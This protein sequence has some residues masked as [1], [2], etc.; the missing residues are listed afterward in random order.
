MSPKLRLAIPLAA[1]GIVAVPATA[2]AAALTLPP[3]VRY[4]PGAQTVPIQGT[5]FTPGA[6]V[7]INADGQPIDS[8][9]AD[10]AGNFSGMFFAPSLSSPT[11]N[12][13]T[14]QITAADSAGQTSPPVAVPVTRVTVKLPSRARPR[15]RVRYRVFGFGSGQRV[16]LHVRRGGR[17]RGS[18]RIGT[19]RGACGN[20]TARQ[21]F[22]PLRRF[23]TGTYEYHFQHARRF[24]PDATV[25]RLQVI[26]TRTFGD[27]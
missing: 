13:Q 8:A 14:F 19:A 12:R 25:V 23:S 9:T 1:A 27:R 15:K 20:L 18:F 3:C 2:H 22:M 24:R 11:R 6:P 26:I 17:T 4:V 16:Y 21:R 5:A 10:A 7:T